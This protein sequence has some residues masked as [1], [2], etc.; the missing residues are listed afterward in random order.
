MIEF[1]FLSELSI[2]ITLTFNLNT[3]LA[4]SMLWA[5]SSQ[6]SQTVSSSC[7]RAM[8]LSTQACGVRPTPWSMSLLMQSRLRSAGWSLAS[9]TASTQRAC[10]SLCLNT[11][12]WGNSTSMPAPSSRRLWRAEEPGMSSERRSE[13]C[14]WNCS[15]RFKRAW[16]G[17][18]DRKCQIN[19]QDI[20]ENCT[21][22]VVWLGTFKKGACRMVQGKS[23]SWLTN[24]LSSSTVSWFW[25]FPPPERY[26]LTQIQICIHLKLVNV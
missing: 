13:L 2:Y 5:F 18:R 25:D 24:D 15:T 4:V 1:S 9:W 11:T 14:C 19:T 10:S 6:C 17:S 22:H 16:D 23:Y 12:S 26:L 7:R 3:N 8:V 20:W 21:K